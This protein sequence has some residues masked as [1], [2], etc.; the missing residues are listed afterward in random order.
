MRIGKLVKKW[1]PFS[2]VQDGGGGGHVEFKK[3]EFVCNSRVL[4]Q[5]FNI[6]TKFG[7]DWSN[8]KEMATDF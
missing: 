4:R 6:S 8:S 5:I 1:Q 3:F 2:E 7:E